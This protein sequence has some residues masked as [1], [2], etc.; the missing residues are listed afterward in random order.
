MNFFGF[1]GMLTGSLI[2]FWKQ[3]KASFKKHPVIIS[4]SAIVPTLLLI[5][6]FTGGLPGILSMWDDGKAARCSRIYEDLANATS[7]AQAANIA[8]KLR[9]ACGVAASDL[10]LQSSV[11]DQIDHVAAVRGLQIA[12]DE[13]TRA[14][15]ASAKELASLYYL[16]AVHESLLNRQASLQ[17]LQLAI[18]LN[19]SSAAP[20]LFKANTLRFLYGDSEESTLLIQA[21]MQ[22]QKKSPIVETY[23]FFEPFLD[24]D[25][26]EVD[27]EILR[28]AFANALNAIEGNHSVLAITLR[29]S[30]IVAALDNLDDETFAK[31]WIT[32]TGKCQNLSNA[33][34]KG[35][36]FVLPYSLAYQ[37]GHFS[38]MER[39]HALALGAFQESKASVFEAAQILEHHSHYWKRRVAGP[40]NVLSVQRSEKE[41]RRALALVKEGGDPYLQ[42][43][44]LFLLGD[45]IIG[46][47]KGDAHEAYI[48]VKQAI[49][50]ETSLEREN[51]RTRY[52]RANIRREAEFG[53]IKL[54]L[55]RKKDALVSQFFLSQ[56]E[57]ADYFQALSYLSRKSGKQQEADMYWEK[58][59]GFYREYI[60]SENNIDALI[61]F[62]VFKSSAQ[63]FGLAGDA[64]ERA[65]KIANEQND[66]VAKIKIKIQLIEMAQQV[67][68]RHT[69]GTLVQP[70]EYIEWHR[71]TAPENYRKI[72]VDLSKDD[73]PE[74]IEK[75]QLFSNAVRDW[76]NYYGV[77]YSLA[78]TEVNIKVLF[79]DVLRELRK[80]RP[81][82]EALKG[83]ELSGPLTDEIKA[84]SIGRFDDT[85]L[86]ALVALSHDYMNL[87]GF[88]GGI[89]DYDWE[90]EKLTVNGVDSHWEKPDLDL[91]FHQVIL[92]LASA[93]FDID[94]EYAPPF[95]AAFSM[96]EYSAALGDINREYKYSSHLIEIMKRPQFQNRE[97]SLPIELAYVGHAVLM[98][99]ACRE[100]DAYKTLK[101]YR[102]HV[103]NSDFFD[104]EY[105]LSTPKS[106]VADAI[107]QADEE[108]CI[109]LPSE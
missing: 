36:C 19:P 74:H 43:E 46:R 3:A 94:Q 70:K 109:V 41:L 82:W 63:L 26:G 28:T 20:K 5:S 54:A 102:E 60:E 78:E 9:K 84:R 69:F 2:G 16:K 105:V 51:M 14:A 75:E 33:T 49:E 12:I 77:A 39:W 65:Y 10:A 83:L 108:G 71:K 21:V 24:K 17:S 67:L 103:K 90:N 99:K 100:I 38:E 57:R 8:S 13:K 23:S 107:K 35:L 64:L 1:L 76:S 93:S 56:N 40:E 89:F 18:E 50:I 31:Q 29:Y 88:Y 61:H 37:S 58:A 6:N 86:G 42:S 80:A 62:A 91:M 48:L 79:S 4:C 96:M 98:A 95:E 97:L 7:G 45:E 87:F 81:E 30:L 22:S 106:L 52:E 27:P 15:N 68:M 32:Q 66:L 101:E 34:E 85:Y 25:L 44:I 92:D 47:R 53:D 72:M 104:N 73:L 59:K 55:Q 11:F